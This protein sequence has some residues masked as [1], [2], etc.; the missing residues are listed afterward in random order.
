MNPKQNWCFDEDL[1]D[2]IS[3]FAAWVEKNGYKSHD[4][5]DIWGT[6]Y[7]RRARELYYGKHPLG[8][9]LTTPLILMEMI[10]PGLRALFVKKNRFATADAQLLLAFLNLQEVSQKSENRWTVGAGGCKCRMKDGSNRAMNDKRG[11][12]TENPASEFNSQ[13]STLWLDRAKKLAEEL[14]SYSI[15]GYS[16]YCWGYPFDWQSV[17]GVIRK[18]TPL[19]TTTP[20]CFEAFLKLFDMT[21]EV[22]YLEIVRSILSFILKDL[23]D[24]P[25]GEN[26]EA[27]SYTPYDCSKVIN[28]SA[29]RAYVLFEG[30]QRFGAQDYA[31][32][33]WKNLRFILQ[34]QRR[35]GSWL[36][37]ID[38]PGET[39]IDHFHTCFVL[40]NLHKINLR[41]KDTGVSRAIENGYAYY[42][43]E[44]FHPNGLPKSFAIEPRM[45]IIRLEM[46][47]VA[48]AINLG[49]LLRGQI[50]GAFAMAHKLTSLVRSRFQL[51]DGYFITRIYVNDLKH[52]MPF[53]RW[54][55][56][57][58][59]YA[60]TN[61]LAASGPSA[62]QISVN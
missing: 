5:Y 14:L 38:N 26:A 45:Q 11:R 39:F 44:L 56:A 37:A 30:A 31:D 17:S 4:P 18:N 1:Q 20:Y 58:L 54:P 57:Q 47:N 24:T 50:P 52:K 13:P 22:R 27:A 59:F 62:S 49:V 23:K 3:K 51:R 29:Y 15:P 12:I 6:H 41:L 10:C 60:L 25:A 42:E 36:Y 28:A 2:M 46:Y 40:K 43:R 35:D 33:A 21:G 48:E 16:G 9:A 8:V 53:L 34:R 32:K 19:I 55:Q 61:L 7:G